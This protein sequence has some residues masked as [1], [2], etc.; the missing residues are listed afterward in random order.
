ML[1][2]LSAPEKAPD[3]PKISSPLVAQNNAGTLNLIVQ[4]T[5][6]TNVIEASSVKS[7]EGEELEIEE[8]E[9]D[10]EEPLVKSPTLLQFESDTKIATLQESN[11]SGKRKLDMLEDKYPF[12]LVPEKRSKV[13]HQAATEIASLES[14][15][16]SLNDLISMISSESDA[17]RMQALEE[18]IKVFKDREAEFRKIISEQ[19]A[20]IA[21][22]RAEV[23]HITK[24]TEH[25]ERVRMVLEKYIKE[26]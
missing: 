8:L 4:T 24:K 9:D 15:Q 22:L 26:L 5:E 18:T 21:S 12:P 25:T 1:R 10:D 16:S 19:E 6:V 2:H 3:I 20:A 11:A 17:D 13:S 14:I 7:V 23:K